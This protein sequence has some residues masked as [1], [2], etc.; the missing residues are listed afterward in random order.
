M[1]SV[2]DICNIALANLGDDATI[3]SIDPPEG[4]PQAEHCAIFYPIA[5]DMVIEAHPWVFATK[6]IA[7][8]EL[9]SETTT[10][11][12]AYA[13]PADALRILA[14]LPSDATSDISYMPPGSG[15]AATTSPVEYTCETLESGAQVIYTDQSNAQIQY[16]ARI[17]DTSLFSPTVTLA[18][19][20]Q[21]SSFLAGPVV[22]GTDGANEAQRW[23]RVSQ[24]YISQAK[25]YDA[26]QQHRPIN[27]SVPWIA[28]R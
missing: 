4:S 9:T 25:T 16:L 15:I 23:A 11:S 14:V 17:D 21:L 26:N 8:A 2:I 7:G 13:R 22:K 20:A 27:Q 18:I 1:S 10:W 12:Y 28:G 5:R 19:A 3:A 6:R 24:T